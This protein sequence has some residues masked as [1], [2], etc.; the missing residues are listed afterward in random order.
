MMCW[1]EATHCEDGSPKLVSEDGWVK[2][3]PV[4]TIREEGSPKLTMLSYSNLDLT[5]YQTYL[6]QPLSSCP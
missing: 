2:L 5:L 1:V 4:K 6:H 3:L